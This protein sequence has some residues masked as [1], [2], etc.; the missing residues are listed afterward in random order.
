M[1]EHERKLQT[2]PTDLKKTGGEVAYLPNKKRNTKKE[3]GARF[4][5]FSELAKIK[6]TSVGSVTC[7]PRFQVRFSGVSNR[8]GEP[9]NNTIIVAAADSSDRA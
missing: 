6:A 7:I 3:E 4:F 1:A 8:C 5:E 9:S 2:S